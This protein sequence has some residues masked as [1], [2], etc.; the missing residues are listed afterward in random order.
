ME[1]NSSKSPDRI[2]RLYALL[3]STGKGA[4]RLDNKAKNFFNE[5]IKMS[6]EQSKKLR[7]ASSELGDIKSSA[8][9]NHKDSLS[10][11]SEAIELLKSKKFSD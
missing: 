8:H 1:P 11:L 3:Q 2:H 9:S 5:H 10:R 6:V 7:L 4:S